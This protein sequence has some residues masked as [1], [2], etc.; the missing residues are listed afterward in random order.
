MFAS[1]ATTT[2]SLDK[3]NIWPTWHDTGATQVP[4][5]EHVQKLQKRET[6]G[7]LVEIAQSHTDNIRGEM[8]S[9]DG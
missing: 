6:V 1:K 4:R 3:C 2:F 7:I 5:E 8:N 9:L